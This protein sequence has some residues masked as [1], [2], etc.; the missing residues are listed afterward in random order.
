MKKFNWHTIRLVL[1][2]LAM[3]FLYS[4]S[5]KRNAKR[6]INEEVEITFFQGQENKFLTHEIVNNLLKQKLGGTLEVAKDKVDLNVL[7]SALDSQGLIEKAEIFSSIDGSLRAQIKQKT[8]IVR[9]LSGNTSY[10]IDNKGT[11]MPLSDNYSER[12]PLVVGA[13]E[14]NGIGN[15]IGL[16]KAIHNDVFLNKNITGITILPSGNVVMTNREYDYKIKFGKPINVD[17]K[18]KNYKAFF[19]Y[20]AKDTLAKDYKEVNLIFTNEVIGKKK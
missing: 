19:C 5:S 17:S 8:P 6:V 7:E 15:Y 4:F 12:V 3:V 16:F 10:Y 11:K 13:L 20:T 9:F 18:L 2:V 1:I 14:E